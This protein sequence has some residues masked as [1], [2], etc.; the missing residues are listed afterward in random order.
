MP[1]QKKT[2]F[3]TAATPVAADKSS[4]TL[5]LFNWLKTRGAGVLLHP[6]CLPSNQGCGVFDGNVVVFLEF[7]KASGMKY[8]QVCPLGPTGYGD[9]PY[10]CFSAFA[11]NPYLIDLWPLVHAGLVEKSAMDAFAVLPVD[12]VDYNAL[13]H[14]KPR[15]LAN[16]Y[17]KF[18]QTKITLPYGDFAEFCQRHAHWLDAYAYYRA[19][20]DHLNNAAWWE[21]P[22]EVRDFKRAQTSPLIKQLADAIAA[23]QFGQYLFFGQWAQVRG[24][25]RE[26]GIEII[27]DLPIFVAGDS[28]DA[29]SNPQLFELDPKTLLPL[30]VAGVPPDYFSADGQLWGNPLYDWAAHQAEGY[31]WWIARMSSTFEMC[32]IVRIDHF[33]GF[34]E[35]WRIPSP[36]TTA[37]VGAWTPGPGIDLFRA[38]KAAFPTARIIAEDLGILTESVNELLR[39]TGLPGMLVLQFAWASDAGNSYLPHN[40]TQ[41]SVIY[42]GTHDNDTTQGWYR[43]A[44]TEVEKD[45]VRRYL[46]VSGNDVAWDFIRAA[47]AS[48]SRLAIVSLQDILSLDSSARFN[49]PAVPE[50][51]WQWRYRADALEKISASAPKYLRELAQL[52]AR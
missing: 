25:A 16:A 8:W 32:D 41:N 21:W 31:K 50:G 34:D 14:L 17:A 10:Q 19:L 22:A 40:A 42:P 51:N 15:L 49:T 29:W 20:K 26:H 47:Y 35:Y 2:V 6:T 30:A 27:G 23:Y 24:A 4:E 43:N 38:F 28:A 12:H 52:C 9:S 3:K 11:G 44:A 39:A 7:L 5:P 46:R 13:Y 37:R 36:A 33:R 18:K 1:T 48:V 45:Y